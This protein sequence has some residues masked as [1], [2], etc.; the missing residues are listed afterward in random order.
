MVSEANIG[1]KMR[2]HSHLDFTRQIRL[3]TILVGDS[4][5]VRWVKRVLQE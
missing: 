5:A 4:R 1:R 3:I 2:G